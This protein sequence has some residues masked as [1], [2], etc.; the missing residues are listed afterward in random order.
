MSGDKEKWKHL[1]LQYM[2]VLDKRYGVESHTKV[3]M[4]LKLIK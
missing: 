4:N 2:K 1:P 3:K